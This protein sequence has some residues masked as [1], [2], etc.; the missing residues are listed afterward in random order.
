ME[1]K[2]T[3]LQRYVE[4]AEELNEVLGLEPQI[5]TKDATINQIASKIREASELITEDDVFTVQ[6]A[7]VIAD[8]TGDFDEPDEEEL[9]QIED[10][11]EDDFE[12]EDDDFEDEDEDEDEDDDFE[13]EEEDEEELTVED[14]RKEIESLYKRKQLREI[15]EEFEIFEDL[16]PKLKDLKTGDTLKKAMLDILDE[17]LELVDDEEPE[18]EP[19]PRLEPKKKETTKKKPRTNG[20]SLTQQCREFIGTKIEEGKYTR[21]ELEDLASQKFSDL[22]ISSI[23]VIITDGKNPKYNKFDKLVIE[24]EKGVLSFER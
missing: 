21:K 4:A 7:G 9:K 10:E 24:D 23:K 12:D 17:E 2:K 19:A 16:R 22:S 3:R 8:L 18:P 6:T 20:P 13:D 14:L 1:K 15:V 5:E 11:D